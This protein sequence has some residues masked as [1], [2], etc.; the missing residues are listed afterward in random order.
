MKSE[1]FTKRFADRLRDVYGS[2]VASI[3]G[4]EDDCARRRYASALLYRLIFLYFLQHR[5][6]L[7]GD[8]RYLQH[9]LAEAQPDDESFYR[10]FLRPLFVQTPRS[11][12]AFVPLAALFIEHPS[13][14]H[15][16]GLALPNKIFERI[17]SF[18]DEYD[19]Q[20]GE[21][22]MDSTN[23]ITYNMLGT[24]FGQEVGQK[25]M[26]AY[27]TPADITNYIARNTLLPA[28]F[29]RTCERYAES[30]GAEEIVWQQLI[31]QPECYIFPTVRFGNEL[32][33]PPEIAA[34]LQDVAQRQLWQ[35]LA[36]PDYALPGEIWREVI[37]RRLYL[38]EVR[39][40]L[41]SD[42]P[43]KLRR[44]VTWNLDQHQL[45]LDT[46]HNCQQPAFLEAYYQSLRSLTVLDPTCGSGAF[47]LATIP[48]LEPL[49]LACLTRMQALLSTNALTQLYRSTFQAHLDKAGEPGQWQQSVLTWICEDNLYGVDLMEEA[50]EICRL[51]LFLR[52]LE[53]LPLQ[54]SF[55]ADFGRHMCVGNSLVSS[56]NTN[57]EKQVKKPLS[58]EENS[59]R[60]FHWDQAFPKVMA[61]GGFDVVMGNP[62][63]VEYKQVKQFYTV[64]GYATL[65][66]GNLYALTM[67]RSSDLL[68]PGG[69]FGMIVPTSATCTDG[70]RSLQKQ[71]L[72]Q[73]ELHIA[74]FSDQRGRLF[75]LPHPR[76]CIILYEKSASTQITPGK[77]FATPY[78]KPERTIRASLFERIHY[79]E[80]TQQVK[81]GIIP[82]YGSELEKTIQSKLAS[83]AH[84][85]GDFL[86]PTGKFEV[87]Y[88]RKLS[89]FVQITPFIPFIRDSS[90]NTRAPS[91]LKSLS[92][93]SFVQ[94]RIAFVALNSNLFYWLLTTSSDCRNLNLREIKSLPL[95]LENM[96]LPIKR[97]LYELSLALELSLYF[98]S[99]LRS[100]R[101]KERE[102]LTIQCISPAYSKHLIDKVDRALAEHYGFTDDELD[103]LLSYDGKY[104]KM[105]E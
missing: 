72:E 28:L 31:Q 49:Y 29:T 18:F 34:G 26:G 78:V 1:Y 15:S 75:P 3:K 35:E 14:Q 74:S 93:A 92:F 71:L 40:N 51:R 46:L 97:K 2:L 100:M 83:Q 32:A 95:D 104:R 102:P 59:Q 12:L 67:E 103:F 19:W 77:V 11:E 60:A 21:P 64:D 16:P 36:P 22:S 41:N 23:V 17:F 70:Y 42:E 24:L 66:T 86:S 6:L 61:Q 47:L 81:P 4:C 85:L 43:D 63:Y 55:P 69:K 68:S 82:R 101:F 10:D 9:H 94:T 53:T 96:S 44:L 57:P 27:Y 73:Q 56:L 99:S 54:V 8:V 39:Y 13:E 33:L 20:S 79:T 62:P 37:A 89:W 5:S 25:E 50:V 30:G 87:Y 45:A 91:E 52:V 58:S 76:L 90:G 80:V 105:Q 48:L 88:T 98:N 7:A 84:C 65:E 38:E